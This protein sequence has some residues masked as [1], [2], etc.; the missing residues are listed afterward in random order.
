MIALASRERA[1]DPWRSIAVSGLVELAPGSIF[2]G[3]YRVIRPLRAGGMGSLYIVEQL[4]TNKLRALKRMLPGIGAQPA[5]RRRFELEAKVGAR[6]QSDHVVEVIASGIDPSSEAPFLVME[7]LEGEDLAAYVERKGALSPAEVRAIAE[8]IGHALGEA[9]RASIVHRDLKPANVFLAAPRRRGIPFMVKVLDFGIARIVAEAQ[10]TS[11]ATQAAIGTPLWMAPEQADPGEPITPATD[12]W[13]LGLLVFWMLTGRFFWKSAYAESAT[14]MMFMREAFGGAIP[15]ASARAAEL[16]CSE[17]LPEGFDAWFARCVAER[18]AARFCNAMDAYLALEP[19][20]SSA[21]AADGELA[22]QRRSR[23]TPPPRLS[24]PASTEA[25]PTPPPPAVAAPLQKTESG[26]VTQSPGALPPPRSR[27]SD[28]A[29]SAPGRASAESA[30][31]GAG[32]GVSADRSPSAPRRF[33]LWPS[34]FAAFA[35]LL[36]LFVL[37]AERS[38]ASRAEAPQSELSA[39]ADLASPSGSSS[40][41]PAD[42]LSD[43]LAAPPAPP[44]SSE[45]AGDPTKDP[46]GAKSSASPT[47]DPRSLHDSLGAASSP[48]PLPPPP[49]AS[50]SLCRPGGGKRLGAPCRRRD[51][52]CSDRCGFGICL[53]PRRASPRKTRPR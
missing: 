15:P 22:E 34:L 1:H 39:P 40:A 37:L 23:L 33:L 10:T 13:A 2:A 44:S 38:R 36:L 28:R 9:H 11:G 35:A 48:P 52:C 30:G 16:G 27:P 47:P 18:A 17:L 21:D 12:V 7:L 5:L 6:I 19:L 42:P 41:A 31:A 20:L 14:V 26:V 4:S 51:E 49:P 29:G 46:P 25:M 50:A 24:I 45:P 53:P 8:P 43:P 32:A 3:D